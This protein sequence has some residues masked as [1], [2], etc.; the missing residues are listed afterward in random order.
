MPFHKKV[1]KFTVKHGKKVGKAALTAVKQTALTFGPGKKIKVAY[2]AGQIAS[3]T[4]TKAHKV[5]TS[6]TTKKVVKK[7]EKV[8]GTGLDAATVGG[9]L[10][11]S[12]TYLAIGK[13][14][15]V[16]TKAYKGVKKL[17][18]VYK[19]PVAV[20]NVIDVAKGNIKTMKTDVSKAAKYVSIRGKALKAATKVFIKEI[21]KPR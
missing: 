12:A 15:N 3:K 18:N 19:Q 16:G 7:F 14:I 11:L 2:K 9:V 20:K 5:I 8:V 17:K 6:P 1:K 13:A 21:R 10:G 4:L